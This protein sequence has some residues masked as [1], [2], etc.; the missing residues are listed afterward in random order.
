MKPSK[1]RTAF[2][3][4]AGVPVGA[5]MGLWLA[6]FLQMLNDWRNDKDES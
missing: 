3:V 4:L 2:W 6:G 1:F 5:V